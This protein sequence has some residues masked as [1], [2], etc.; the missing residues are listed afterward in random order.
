MDREAK[1]RQFELKTVYRNAWDILSTW[2][3]CRC[4][5]GACPIETELTRLGTDP[6]TLLLAV[7]LGQPQLIG[8]ESPRA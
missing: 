3:Q 2:S 7:C 1:R 8:I 4:A 5:A 6:G